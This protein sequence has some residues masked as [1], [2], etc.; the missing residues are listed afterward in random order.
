M[1]RQQRDRTFT[2]SLSRSIIALLLIV[3]GLIAFLPMMTHAGGSAGAGRAVHPN[4]FTEGTE[5]QLSIPSP[6]SKIKIDVYNIRGIHI[7]NL[8]PGREGAEP[9]DHPPGEY[10]VPWDGKD[11]FGDP[12]PPGIYICVLYANSSIVPSVPVI[13][14]D[15]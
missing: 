11:K 10:P 4:P 6:G 15:K 3:G 5:F 1:Q 9:E 7:R 14:M 13:K 8:F 2:T 12:V